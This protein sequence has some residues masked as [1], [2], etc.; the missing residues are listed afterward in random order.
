[1]AKGGW[2]RREVGEAPDRRTP[3]VG[4][5]M[6]EG[7]VEWAG[8]GCWAGSG[9]CGPAAGKKKGDGVGC[10]AGK[11]DR[12]GLVLFLFFFSFSTLYS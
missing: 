7:E 12:E 2:G 5:R 9:S 3:P 8:G 6:R 4:E 11:K 1:V 10:W